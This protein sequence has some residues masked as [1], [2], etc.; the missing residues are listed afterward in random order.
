MTRNCLIFKNHEMAM[1]F[2]QKRYLLIIY[3]F[4]IFKKIAKE[5]VYLFILVN[6]VLM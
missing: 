3:K 5:H 6:P 4:K 1:L 2:M